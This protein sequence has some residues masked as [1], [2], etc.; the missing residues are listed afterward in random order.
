MLLAAAHL[1][2]AAQL[3]Q[4]CRVR[5][6]IDHWLV[7]DVLRSISVSQSVECLVQI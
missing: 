2:L 3:R 5:V 7:L 6:A 4:L 1:Q